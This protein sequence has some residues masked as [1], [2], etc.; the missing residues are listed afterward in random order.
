MSNHSKLPLPLNTS[1]PSFTRAT[2]TEA[3]QWLH[4]SLIWLV[5]ACILGLAQSIPALGVLLGEDWI[6]AST[7][8]LMLARQ[9]AL[10]YGW[11]ISNIIGI[12][13]Y[14]LILGNGHRGAWLRC[15]RWLWHASVAVG[16]CTVL[17]GSGSGLWS[18]PFASWTLPPLLLIL[19]GITYIIASAYNKDVNYWTWLPIISAFGMLWV[20]L[21]GAYWV[22]GDG[23]LGTLAMS[24][25]QSS[26]S[27]CL[28]VICLTAFAQ[29]I[30]WTQRKNWCIIS[31]LLI[32]LSLIAP[33]LLGAFSLETFPIPWKIVALSQQ[34]GI[35]TMSILLLASLASFFAL[36]PAS[37][38]GSISSSSAHWYEAGLI[39]MIMWMIWSLLSPW[40]VDWRQFSIALWYENNLWLYGSIGMLGLAVWLA[41][42]GLKKGKT[43]RF[44]AFGGLFLIIT[45]GIAV[46]ANL[47]V[48]NLPTEKQ[49]AFLSSWA[50][51]ISIF[52]SITWI[53]LALAAICWWK[54]NHKNIGTAPLNEE[55]KRTF[56][57][58]QGL[59]ALI[60][61]SS[62]GAGTWYYVG[63]LP[64]DIS[65][66][67]VKRPGTNTTGARVFASEGCAVCHTQM[68]R[69][70]PSGNDLQYSLD[71]GGNGKGIARISIPEDYEPEANEGAAHI[72][73]ARIG[74]DLFQ[75]QARVENYVR[76]L[77]PNG[78]IR[79]TATPQEWL[80]LHL[81]NPR[82][83][84]FSKPWTLC[85][86]MP[87]LF[88]IRPML[89]STPSPEALPLKTPDNYEIIP[90]PEAVQLVAYLS[91]LKRGELS[92]KIGQE[93]ATR[94]VNFLN[95][96][97]ITTPPKLDERK[98][99]AK[100]AAIAHE[101]GRQIYNTRCAICHGNEG[102]GNPSNYPPILKSE[103]ITG[104]TQTLALII[105][106]GL[107]GPISVQGKAWNST[108][109]P[110]GI[111][112]AKEI[113]ALINYLRWQYG[114]LE[115]PPVTAEQISEW[116]SLPEIPQQ[117]LRTQDLPKAPVPQN[118]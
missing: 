66:F 8:R 38:S 58:I 16:L 36:I 86:P 63:I 69:A 71:T 40:G 114:E 82:D 106:Y 92:P 57:P 12:I 110:T 59:L 88:E 46:Y 104:D 23:I 112:Q 3:A 84:M 75:L 60:I 101:E 44:W 85:P 83:P 1:N 35:V 53:L 18:M 111:S 74:P 80:Y 27:I 11:G 115:A 103:W 99:K 22:G 20:A 95:P 24:C 17:W 52:E 6:K 30:A 61:M 113:A 26:I 56:R 70:L 31:T 28:T 64:Q 19:G 7:G 117:P 42:E 107:T 116:I 51:F 67:E 105:R 77:D 81:Y 15:L 41:N 50:S 91:T 10:I 55:T 49:S 33:P 9:G 90:S 118:K 13:V 5:I 25:V 2:S 29:T 54:I 102:K 94:K 100:H 47:S 39:A 98:F 78:R 96:K 48:Q 37:K 4:Q 72:G 89:G 79:A 62:I 21:T 65:S 45:W 97:Y 68:I 109:L 108:M 14:V 32:L 34:V 93:N 73:Y 76:Y 43:E 87:Q